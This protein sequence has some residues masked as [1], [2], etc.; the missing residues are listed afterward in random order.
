MALSFLLRVFEA[1]KAYSPTTSRAN[2]GVDSRRFVGRK[3]Q[4]VEV[5]RVDY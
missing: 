4:N 5:P 3:L 2:R 1:R